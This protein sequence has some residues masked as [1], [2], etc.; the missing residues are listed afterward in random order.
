MYDEVVALAELNS[1]LL[2]DPQMAKQA[3]QTILRTKSGLDDLVDTL[4]LLSNPKF[5][6][7]LE[8]GLKEARRGKAVKLSTKELRKRLE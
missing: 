8:Q 3:L 6:R 7:N 2:E 5:R 4:E 1:K